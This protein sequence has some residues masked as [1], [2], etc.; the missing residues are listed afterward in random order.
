MS[1]IVL[2][3]GESGTGKS[4]SIKPLPENETYI[5]NVLGKPLPFKGWKNKYR[6]EK[7]KEKNKNLLVTDDAATICKCLLTISKEKPEIKHIIIDDFQYIMCNEF[8]RRALEKGYEKFSQIGQS[9][10]NIIM[11]A[12]SLRSDLKIFFLTHSDTDMT[13]K[14]KVKT[15]GKM[16]EDKVCIEGMFTMVFYSTKIDDKYVFLTQTQDNISA[17]TPHEMFSDKFI[18]NDLMSIS[19]KID[20]YDKEDDIKQ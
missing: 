11:Q 17:K 15:I 1:T 14:T 16:L 10:W 12:S 5:I 2:V 9:A 4:T 20:L 6:E 8:M 13:G 19:N 7:V 18:D 3:Y